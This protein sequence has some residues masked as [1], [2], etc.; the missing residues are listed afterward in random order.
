M[1]KKIE[2]FSK[3]PSTYLILAI[4]AV[5]AFAYGRYLGPLQSVASKLPKA[6]A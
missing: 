3:K 4:G 5:L 6:G 2:S 1:L